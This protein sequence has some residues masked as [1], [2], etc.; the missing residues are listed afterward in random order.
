MVPIDDALSCVGLTPSMYALSMV[1]ELIA[2][3]RVPNDACHWFDESNDTIFSSNSSESGQIKSKSR[4]AVSGPLCVVLVF[5]PPFSGLGMFCDIESIVESFSG[6]LGPLE[7][8]GL[9]MPCVG[10]W[11]GGGEI[12]CM[13]SL[14][15][16]SF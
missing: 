2:I 1:C 16:C 10:A 13:P 8:L 5:V 7:E 6:I 12:Y 3:G 4:S 11:L 14:R 9:G 15:V